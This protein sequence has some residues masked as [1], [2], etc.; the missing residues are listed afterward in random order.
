[1]PRPLDEALLRV[2]VPVVISGA[3]ASPEVEPHPEL[4]L[5]MRSEAPADVCAEGAG[6]R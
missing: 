6:G 3:L 1:V 5:G 4:R 2:V